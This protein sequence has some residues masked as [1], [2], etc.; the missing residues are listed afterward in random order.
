MYVVVCFGGFFFFH[1]H[2]NSGTVL[3]GR[4][5]ALSLATWM[6]LLELFMHTV[7][8]VTTGFHGLLMKGELHVWKDWAG[9]GLWWFVL[10]FLFSFFRGGS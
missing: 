10:V 4:K 6:Q 5:C 1:F 8:D 2:L 7:S 3:G 9:L